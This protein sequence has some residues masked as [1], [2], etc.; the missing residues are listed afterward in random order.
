MANAF[1]DNCKIETVLNVYFRIIPLESFIISSLA[2][3]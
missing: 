2:T 3:L 1:V